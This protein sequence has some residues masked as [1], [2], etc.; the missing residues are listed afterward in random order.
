MLHLQP[1]TRE[2]WRR[3]CMI[4][5]DPN[6]ACPIEEKWVM[7]A[8]FSIVQSVYDPDWHSRL[9][10]DGQTP[11]GFVF[12]GWWQEKNAPLLCR[13]MIDAAYQGKGYGQ[14]ALPLVLRQ[15]RAQYGQR[16]VYLTLE[17]QN[18]RAVHIYEKFGFTDTGEQD[19]GEDIYV[20]PSPGAGA[21]C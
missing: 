8:A 6:H 16:P 3:A 9:I 14:A 12:Y 13:Y 20:L 7:S 11:V 5:T 1:I 19:E 10:V 18:T 21:P 15:M 2:N 17:K 4:S